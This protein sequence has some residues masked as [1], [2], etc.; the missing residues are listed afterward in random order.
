LELSDS[1]RV[2][3]PTLLCRFVPALRQCILD[4]VGEDDEVV[5][6]RDDIREPWQ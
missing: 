4:A 6:S 3:C 2:G 1:E 5:Y